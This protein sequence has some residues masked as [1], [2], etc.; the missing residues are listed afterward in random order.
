MLM[1]V[2]QVILFS[3]RCIVDNWTCLSFSP[4]VHE[5]S[6]V[7]EL[8]GGESQALNSVWECPYRVVKDTCGSLVKPAFMWDG[9]AR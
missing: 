9:A 7:I 4:L 8:P 1:K 5:A 6:S 2:L 3:K